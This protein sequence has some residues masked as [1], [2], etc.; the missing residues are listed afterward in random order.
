MRI[1]RGRAGVPSEQ[2]AE[3]FT[4]RV[5]AD[6]VLAPEDGV[7]VNNVFFEPG[8]RTHWHTHAEGQVLQVTH[9]EGWVQM[10]DGAGGR[11]TAGDIVHIGPGEEHWHG[12]GPTS[13]LLHVAVSLGVTDW[14]EPVSDDDYRRVIGVG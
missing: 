9:G 2:R 8:A 6:P 11:I 5:W 7:T 14:L 4:G 13:Y 3:T 1:A 12:A 10:R